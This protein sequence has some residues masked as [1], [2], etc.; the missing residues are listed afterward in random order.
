MKNGVDTDGSSPSLISGN[1]QCLAETKKTTDRI[2]FIRRRDLNYGPSEG[3]V[4]PP[5]TE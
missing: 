1:R 3:R 4:L 2:S 5:R